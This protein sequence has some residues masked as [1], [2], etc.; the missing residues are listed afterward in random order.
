MKGFSTPEIKNKMSLRASS[1]GEI[2]MEDVFVPDEN[3]FPEIKGL[4]G[5]FACLNNA[6]Y[7]IA[8]GTVGAAEDCYRRARQYVMERKQFGYPLAATQLIQCSCWY[9]GWDN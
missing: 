6:R 2:V 4:K 8:W 3:V 1:T 5:P 7:G 9:I